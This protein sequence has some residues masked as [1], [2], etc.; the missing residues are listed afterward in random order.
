MEGMLLMMVEQAKLS[1]EMFEKHGVEE[2][3]FTAA[4]IFHN[5]MQ[6][7]EVQKI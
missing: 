2:E 1:D 5:T 3:D 7:P 4:L 6:D